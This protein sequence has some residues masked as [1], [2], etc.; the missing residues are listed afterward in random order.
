M[1]DHTAQPSATMTPPVKE[2]IDLARLRA[3]T[4]GCAT[5]VHLN[6]AGAG[7]MPQPVLEAQLAHLRLEAEIGG[8]EAADAAA[9]E[10][11]D[12]YDAAAA[13]L[14]CASRNIAF[15]P[16]ATAAFSSALSSVPFEAGDVIL[17][18]RDDYVSNQI[19]FLSLAKRFG[20]RVE[21]APSR[22][23]GGVDAEAMAWLIRTRHPRL[24]VVTHV[25]TNSGLVQPVAEVGRA[26]R[27]EEVLY[28][29]D[30]CQ[31]AGQL[32]LDVGAIGCDFLS[33]GCR[34]FLRGPRGSGLLYA[35]DRALAAGL[36]PLFIDCRG[37]EWTEADAYAPR[38]SAL[39]FEE[40]EK[41][42]AAVRGAGVAMRYA[43]QVGLPAIAARN[44]R[45]AQSLRE[46]LAEIEG[47]R[48]LDR[49]AV[50]CAIVTFTVAGW[51]PAP[52][53][54]ALQARGFNVNVS[55]P[56]F[57]VIDFADKRARWALRCA[58]HYYNTED[59]LTRFVGTVGELARR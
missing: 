48:V 26:C 37:A 1:E 57:A 39:R 14:G 3:E 13:L 40:M 11:Q 54:A 20:V 38:G 56:P 58:P 59:E 43:L 33:A 17:T 36:E 6:N 45:L 55:L 52:F 28:L 7:L 23:E 18:T 27:E 15:A 25:P 34:K 53:K 19:A 21:R 24:V 50:R 51:E 44:G 16:N 31:S 8:Y 41:S 46:R 22:P 42:F 30:A 4:P 47:V 12:F 5:R 2:E 35:S 29:V 9:A 32:P 10:I 49:G